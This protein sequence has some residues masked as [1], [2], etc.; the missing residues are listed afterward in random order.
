MPPRLGNRS[1][2]KAATKEVVMRA[3]EFYAAL[4]GFVDSLRRSGHSDADI[5]EIVRKSFIRE[6]CESA[7]QANLPSCCV[8]CA[9]PGLELCERCDDTL[10]QKL[11]EA[12]YG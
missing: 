5:V 11:D 9:A 7:P 1:V 4:K 6:V 12:L 3:S 2:L 8:V 10:R